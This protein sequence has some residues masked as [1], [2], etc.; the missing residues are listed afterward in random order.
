[1]LFYV[2]FILI[3]CIICFAVY[4]IITKVQIDRGYKRRMALPKVP[5]PTSS[6]DRSFDELLRDVILKRQTHEQIEYEAAHTQYQ[7][8]K[9]WNSRFGYKFNIYSNDH[10]ISGKPHFHFDNQEKGI[11]A[12]IDFDGNILSI[13]PKPIPSNIYKELK[14]FLAKNYV[15]KILIENWMNKN[16]DQ[17]NTINKR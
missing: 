3:A 12:K 1:M 11:K 10:L 8:F 9:E 7:K 13:G 6:I 14:Y 17:S 16:P 5:I 2:F 4:V 15:Q